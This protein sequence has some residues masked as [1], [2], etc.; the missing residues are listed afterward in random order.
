MYMLTEPPKAN[1]SVRILEKPSMKKN[2]S[3]LDSLRWFE[4]LPTQM[5]VVPR[6]NPNSYY[7]VDIPSKYVIH[8]MNCRE[9]GDELICDLIEYMRPLY[10]QYTPLASPYNNLSQGRCQRIIVNVEKKRVVQE[11][12]RLT[13]SYPD[14]PA[15]QHAVGQQKLTERFWCLGIAGYRGGQ[16][17]FF[18]QVVSGSFISDETECWL[19]P[20]GVFVCSEP[21][22]IP[23][24]GGSE[25]LLAVQFSDLVK[26][27]RGMHFFSPSSISHGPLGSLIF[28]CALPFPLHGFWREPNRPGV[29]Q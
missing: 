9:S 14:F 11:I 16:G 21:L 19:A 10:N 25:M 7:F 18:N 28:P 29:I 24:K 5:L 20:K 2:K 12:S 3:I 6:L 8:W 22:L 26:K 15:I 1:I 13:T 4:N 17:N 23:T 27:E